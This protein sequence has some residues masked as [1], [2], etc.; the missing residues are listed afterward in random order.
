MKWQKVEVDSG[1][2]DPHATY[3]LAKSPWKTTLEGV[4]CGRGEV[5]LNGFESSSKNDLRVCS[6]SKTSLGPKWTSL[7]LECIK[8]QSI[9]LFCS[10]YVTDTQLL[11]VLQ[12]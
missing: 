1:M 6:N 8:W 2:W 5:N 7:F 11:G 10:I 12:W 4:V 3:M 9:L